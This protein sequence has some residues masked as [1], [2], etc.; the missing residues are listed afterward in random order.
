VAVDVTN[1]S[2][3]FLYHSL[4]LQEMKQVKVIEHTVYRLR[5][6]YKQEKSPSLKSKINKEISRLNKLL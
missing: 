4:R 5:R 1:K 6:W 2:Q 3:P